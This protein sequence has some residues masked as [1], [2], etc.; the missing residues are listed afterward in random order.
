M[1]TAKTP[2]VEELQAEVDRLRAELSARSADADKPAQKAKD[3]QEEISSIAGDTNNA[4]LDQLYRIVQGI[5]AA[6][7]ELLQSGTDILIKLNDEATA[8]GRTN[9][10]DLA[11]TLS[12]LPPDIYKGYLRALGRVAEVPGRMAEQ[13]TKAHRNAAKH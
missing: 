3:V 10:D 1:A 2:T 4:A 12:Q 6:T 5:N 7:A 8:N 9:Q 13:F 11:K